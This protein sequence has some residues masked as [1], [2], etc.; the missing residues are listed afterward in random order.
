MKFNSKSAL[1]LAQAKYGKD[2]WVRDNG[3]SYRDGELRPIDAEDRA[4][5]RDRLAACKAAEPRMKPLAEWP[6]ETPLGEYKAAK[7][8]TE[9]AWKKWR[10]QREVLEGKC[11]SSR[12]EVGD[13]SRSGLSFVYVMGSGDTWEEALRKAGCLP[14]EEAD[15][16]RV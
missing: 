4:K 3:L 16:A 9:K 6:D 12:F 13:V 2:A 7:A 1:K 5:L 15:D 14:A 10:K 11:F 8:A